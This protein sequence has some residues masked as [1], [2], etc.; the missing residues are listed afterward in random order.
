[1]SFITTI[2]KAK[3]IDRH[4]L[5]VDALIE[6]GLMFVEDA[7]DFYRITNTPHDKCIFFAK[8]G[9]LQTVNNNGKS[10]DIYEGDWDSLMKVV[11]GGNL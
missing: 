11:K 7:D 1:M 10:V 4:L 5:V 8:T 3:P 9:K 2:K 6:A